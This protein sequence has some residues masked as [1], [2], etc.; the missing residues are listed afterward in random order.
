ML[1][2]CLKNSGLKIQDCFEVYMGLRRR[3]QLASML[4]WMEL[5]LREHGE[6]PS[7]EEIMSAYEMARRPARSGCST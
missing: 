1:V 7:R 4:L 3:K 6:Y 5:Y 2:T